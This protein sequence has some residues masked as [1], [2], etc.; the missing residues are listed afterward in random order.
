MEKLL[1]MCT[2]CPQEDIVCPNGSYIFHLN[3]AKPITKCE[4]SIRSLRIPERSLIRREERRDDFWCQ[5][6]SG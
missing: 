5:G 3:H 1:K 6:D 2:P 4:Q